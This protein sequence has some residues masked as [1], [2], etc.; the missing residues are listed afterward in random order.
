M[1]IFI[2]GH[3]YPQDHI[4]PY[5]KKKGSD[6]SILPIKKGDNGYFVEYIG[7]LFIT[8]EKYSGPVF[9]LPKSFLKKDRA[10]KDV[11][12]GMQGV[13]PENIID[14]DDKDNILNL[15]GQETFLPELSLW[16]FRAMTRYLEDCKKDRDEER[17]ND[18]NHITPDSS[19]LDHDFLSTA[20]H[21]M[22]YLSDHR[23][24]FTQISNINNSGRSAIDWNKTIQTSPFFKKGKPYYTDLRIKDKALNID[25]ELIILYYSV[26][27]YLK[28][29]F[30][31]PISLGDTP[32]TLKSPTD[33]QRYLDTGLGRRKM[34]DMKG[35][36]YR[37][38]L[39]SLWNML[40]SFFDTNTGTDDNQTIKEALTVKN[41]E[42]VF[43][44]MI[45]T[46]IGD[47]DKLS[48]LKK[49]KDGKLID[50]IYLDKSL[51]T[52]DNN[53]FYIGD[54][55]YYPEDRHP[56]GISLYKQFTYA[57]NVIQYNINQYYIEQ[58]ANLN[59]IR[60]RDEQTEGYNVTPNF[61][62]C[63]KIEDR[64]LDFETPSF[65]PSSWTPKKINKHFE[66]R[67]FDRDTLLLREYEIN[68]IFVIAAY[69]SYEDC[70][71][72]SIRSDIRKDMI[73]FL[74]KLYIFFRIEPKPIPYYSDPKGE[75]KLGEIPFM[76]YHRTRL[77]GRAYKVSD[78]DTSIL[79]AFEKNT[80]EG[81]D[82]L[83]DARANLPTSI[84]DP[85]SIEQN[86]ELKP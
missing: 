24:L 59:T 9:I 50:H 43:E 82:D 77:Q 41:F 66:D 18:L 36:Y 56:E 67:L 81:D 46:L 44:K 1:L 65:A 3:Q 40:Y 22:D 47:T 52:P 62:I 30:R 48:E 55:K 37:D 53:I 12:L 27:K 15:N 76:D 74:N 78:Q 45:D 7:Y 34:R 54:S 86:I 57:R 39:V 11:L 61:F 64:K 32:Y 71:T 31:F 28:E 38:D 51:L 14:T 16:L 85:Q 58:E 20:V 83:K 80:P 84:A 19:S 29:K 75:N 33:I 10:D 23:N 21:L 70:W 60:Y 17:L 35:K 49:Q 2:E 69:G 63:P 6:E 13:T 68:L 4:V 73:A 79:L 72:A 25:E 26:L 8:S 5:F 42:K